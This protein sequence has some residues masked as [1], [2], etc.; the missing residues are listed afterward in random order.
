MSLVRLLIAAE[1]AAQNRAVRCTA[2]RHRHVAEHP[3]VVTAFNLSGEAAAPLGFCYGTDPQRPKVVVAAE[4]RNR[5]CRFAAINAFA[6]DLV[7]YI[8]PFLHLVPKQRG[9][10]ENA[11]T[12]PMAEDAPQIVAP[13]RTTRD[14]LCV[15]L[16]RSLR[17]LGLGATHEVPED[18][19]WAGSHLSWYAEHTRMPGQSA[20]LAA[21][22]LLSRHYV[23]GQS[24]LENEN[25]ASLLAWIE[26]EPGSGRTA[27][28]VAEDEV[29]GPVPDPE[30]EAE[31]EPKVR[32][33][34]KCTRDG[35][36]RAV[37]EI[38]AEMMERVASALAPA[39]EKTHR[40]LT[41]ARG[42]PEAPSVASRWDG[43]VA[44]WSNHARRALRGIPRFAKRHDAIR[45][46]RMLEQWSSALDRLGYE[47]ALDD[48]LVMADVDAE[49]R[50]VIGAVTAVN[51]DNR[52][53]KPGN[54]RKTQV[55]LVSL[56]LHGFT[57]LLDGETLIWANEA[58]V[59]AVVRSRVGGD[60]ELAII[61]GH[62]SG[63]RVPRVGTDAVFAAM[64]VFGGRPPDSPEAVPWTHRTPDRPADVDDDA[65]DARRT[66][67]SPDLDAAELIAAPV[68]DA[69]ALDDVP[70]VVL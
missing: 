24:E 12:I 23:T 51:V 60:V 2:Y 14:Y 27:I 7:A 15:R 41:I 32:A 67:G 45:A 40:A 63:E 53:V 22:E 58:S 25:L 57:T 44:E 66:D 55:P 69:T 20:F 8:R 54:T 18:T 38:E 59:H 19:Q 9:H 13:N 43:D 48:P 36:A 16:G 65:D 5:E 31:I 68:V 42:I 35:D 30:W 1:A 28:D 26:N 46:A 50:C 4:P 21:T 49:G 29:H 47:E 6:S 37:A 17:Y 56:R 3:F 33:W 11:R 62:K 61:K 39:Y 52:E 10:G 34:S 70:G 64:S